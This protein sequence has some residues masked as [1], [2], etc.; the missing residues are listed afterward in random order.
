MTGTLLLLYSLFWLRSTRLLTL[1]FFI[2]SVLCCYCEALLTC[3]KTS[4][5]TYSVNRSFGT[6]LHEG[7]SIFSY[8]RRDFLPPDMWDI[9]PQLWRRRKKRSY[10]FGELQKEGKLRL[11][12]SHPHTI[13]LMDTFSSS[14]QLPCHRREMSLFSHTPEEL[15][16]V[17]CLPQGE[18]RLP[19]DAVQS[20]SLPSL[21]SPGTAPGPETMAGIWDTV[22]E[23]TLHAGV[24]SLPHPRQLGSVQQL[25]RLLCTHLGE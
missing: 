18:E 10:H 22:A 16:G 15:C 14:S 13:C 21:D 3:G 6:L 12:I 9:P 2:L 25:G 1:H 7:N 23:H 17:G 5:P 4:C 8:I 20:I 24:F 19:G 11:P